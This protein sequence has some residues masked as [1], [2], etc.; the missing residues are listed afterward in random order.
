M[1]VLLLFIFLITFSA[2][3]LAFS[4]RGLNITFFIIA[5]AFLQHIPATIFYLF[6]YDSGTALFLRESAQIQ[7]AAL[8]LGLIFLVFMASAITGYYSLKRTKSAHFLFPNFNYPRSDF[9][10][11]WA[12]LFMSLI[13]IAVALNPIFRSD[14]IFQ[15]IYMVRNESFYAGFSFLIQIVRL[16]ELIGAGFLADLL[17]RKKRGDFS[18]NKYII[19]VAIFFVLNLFAGLIMGGKSHVVIPIAF[20]IF[21]YLNAV[22]KSPLKRMVVPALFLMAIVIVLQIGRVTLVNEARLSNPMQN[23]YKA[24]NFTALDVNIVYLSVLDQ[25]LKVDMAE[26]YYYGA[27][28]IIPRSLWQ[29]K[30]QTINAGGRF[31]EAVQPNS[32]GAWPVFGYNQLYSNFGWLGVIIG[33][34]IFGWLLNALQ[35]IYGRNRNDPLSFVIGMSIALFVLTPNGIKNE[36]FAD[37]I[38]FVIPLFLIKA[39]TH[40]GWLSLNSKRQNTP[41]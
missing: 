31:K 13:G 12:F 29:D 1:F 34:L 35:E 25:E 36:I 10:L 22:S 37:Y 14:N 32:T 39:C 30:P 6:D 41:A 7:N 38:L 21:S 5:Y 2:A 17:I 16:S 23:A 15:A 8:L 33:G 11:F 26:D 4:P 9:L 40:A 18:V 19:P 27:V 3:F 28:G 20:L 24:L